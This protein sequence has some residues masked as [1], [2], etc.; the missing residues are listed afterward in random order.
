MKSIRVKPPK[1]LSLRCP[2]HEPGSSK[3]RV[4][5]YFD[6]TI[7]EAILAYCWY[8]HTS[9]NKF[10]T[11]VLVS[12]IERL[13]HTGELTPKII[14]LYRENGKKLTLSRVG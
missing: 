8:Q 12:Q 3:H 6:S 14:K 5:G 11:A 7:H 1:G 9:Q 13:Q 4:S 2:A 10:V